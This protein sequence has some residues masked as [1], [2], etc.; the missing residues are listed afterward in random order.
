MPER[1][2]SVTLMNVPIVFKNF[3]GQKGQFNAEG[4]R[5][6]HVL[7]EDLEMAREM[8]GDGWNLKPFLDEDEQITA[9]HLS[10]KVNYGGY[11]PRIVRVTKEGRH[12]VDLDEKTVGSLD[13]Q[14]VTSV[15]LTINPYQWEVQGRS[16]ISAYCEQMFVNVEESLLEAKY[17]ALLDSPFDE[18]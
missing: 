12:Q 3:L 13:S 18:D 9:Y 11:P 17:A 15:D 4:E 6:F 7:I 10:V 16:G 5:S 2:P 8:L 14:K 1:K